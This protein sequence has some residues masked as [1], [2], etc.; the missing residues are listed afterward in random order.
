MALGDRR[1]RDVDGTRCGARYPAA[2][3]A[4]CAD[5]GKFTTASLL[6]ITIPIA[7]CD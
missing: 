3:L 5:A 4:K 6:A 2:H 7:Y 1:L